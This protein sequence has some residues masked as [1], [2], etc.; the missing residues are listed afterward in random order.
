MIKY[1]HFVI[2]RFNVPFIREENIDFLF[3]KEY[4]AKRFFLFERFCFRS[5]KNQSCQDFLW[6]VLFDSR[7]PECFRQ[8]NEKLH[9]DWSNYLPIYI[10]MQALKSQEIDECYVSEACRCAQLARNGYDACVIDDLNYEDLTSRVLIPQLM[11]TIIRSLIED[12]TDCV[13]TSRIDN[14]DCYEKDMIAEVQKCVRQENVDKILNFDYG[15]QY[16]EGK[17][18]CQSFYYPNGHFSSIIESI[19]QPLKTVIYWEH[20]FID[21][22]KTV[23][24]ISTKPL[25]MEI[26]HD[27]NVV[28]SLKLD[29]RNNLLWNVDL[30]DYGLKVSWGCITTFISIFTHFRVFLWP[31]IKLVFHLQ[32][33]KRIIKKI[34]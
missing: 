3:D 29:K 12:D 21:R 33:L 24:H 8:I 7:T 25:W 34:V 9:N 5:M 17:N 13:I 18:I 22:Y 26:L 23:L 4:L 15:I 28:N 30:H 20:Y 10:D 14:D 11:D 16:V 31:K 1:K 6:L 27:C 19:S 32:K 2:T